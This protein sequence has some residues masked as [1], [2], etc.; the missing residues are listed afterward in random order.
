MEEVVFE[1]IPLIKA[2]TRLK[3]KELRR[4]IWAISSGFSKYKVAKMVG[5]SPN[6][7]INWTRRECIIL[8]YILNKKLLESEGGS[9]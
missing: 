2:K 6:T 1:W 5:V 3:T 4:V 9:K 7:C 8:S